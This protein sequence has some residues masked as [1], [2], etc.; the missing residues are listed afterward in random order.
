LS[1][2]DEYM[3]RISDYRGTIILMGDF[4]LNLLQSSYY[5][6][7]YRNIIYKHGLSQIIQQPTRITY[8]SATLIDHVIT[9]AKELEYEILISPRISD[10]LIIKIKI[11]TEEGN[12]HFTKKHKMKKTTKVIT[13]NISGNTEHTI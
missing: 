6:N 7:K 11:N 12:K 10:H 5:I 3:E 13:K 2:L 8:D 1:F 9:N 4:N